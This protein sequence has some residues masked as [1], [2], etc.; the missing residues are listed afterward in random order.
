MK[1]SPAEDLRF[2]A[3]PSA[4]EVSALLLRPPDAEL[5]LVLA[6]GAGAG[7]RHAFMENVSRALAVRNVAT[8]RY[9]FPYVERG[10]HRPDPQP[11]LL[12]TVRA[13]VSLARERAGDLPLFA[14]GKSMGGRMTS[15]AAALAPLPDVDGIVFLGFPLH[16]PGRPGI[17]RA[18]HLESAPGPLL[19]MQ[20]TR[21]ELADLELLRPVV[22]DLGE[23]ATLHIIE[24]ADHAFA[25]RK[26]SGRDNAAVIEEI[27]EVVAR[28]CGERAT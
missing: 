10:G 7:M 23:R 25:V 14:G 24:D 18:K 4:G 3:S 28:W 22:Q 2:E 12:A 5:L 6:H 20:G 19:F 9:Q 15:N 27:G 26:R 1:P 17:E 21:D 16:P 13:A 11:I 8:L